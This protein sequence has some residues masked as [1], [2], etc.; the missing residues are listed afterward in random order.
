MDLAS[1]AAAQIN[2]KNGKSRVVSYKCKFCP[3]YHFGHENKRARTL[4]EFNGKL[5]LDPK[6]YSINNS[7]LTEGYCIIRQI[8]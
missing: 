2:I 8:A 1:E 4:K 6:E 7:R 3:S 5:K